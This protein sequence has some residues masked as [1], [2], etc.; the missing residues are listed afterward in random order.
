MWVRGPWKN[1]FKVLNVVIPLV[2]QDKLLLVASYQKKP[3][4]YLFINH[5]VVYYKEIL[6]YF[7][8][9]LLYL[10]AQN[11][12][13]I[14][15]QKLETMLN[16]YIFRPKKIYFPYNQHLLRVYY[17]S[18]AVTYKI[19]GK[20]E[21]ISSRHNFTWWSFPFWWLWNFWEPDCYLD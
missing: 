16:V 10:F 8:C 9:I 17:I 21:I 1:F 19:F 5:N 20:F 14:K 18:H 3:E 6:G 4:V 7:L 15:I 13:T 11:I 2:V 12:L